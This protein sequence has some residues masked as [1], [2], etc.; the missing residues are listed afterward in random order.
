[1]KFSPTEPVGVAFCLD[2]RYDNK[3]AVDIMDKGKRILLKT[4]WNGAGYTYNDPT[5]EEFAIAV[6]E[7]YMFAETQNLSH[8][9]T[10]SQL[11]KVVAQIDPA[12][13]ANAFLYSLSTRA[14][15]Y[16]SAM[17]T[18]YYAKAVP[19]HEQPA[20]QHC[21]CCNWTDEH[22]DF[23]VQ[24]TKYGEISWWPKHTVENKSN[25][26][27]YKFGGRNHNQVQYALFDLIQF[28][29]LPSV[30]PTE[31]D[32]AMFR[33]ILGSIQELEP[34]SKAGAYQELLVKKK[35]IPTNRIEISSLID[36]LGLCG[37]LSTTEH[38]CPE[39]EFRGYLGIDPP[40]IHSDIAYPVCW[41]RARDGVNEARFRK[42]FG[43][44][45]REFCYPEVGY[46]EIACIETM[47]RRK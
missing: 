33:E 20:L 34:R 12:D 4:F 24:K 31:T 23:R 16:R 44:D 42:V 6:E 19:E 10:L 37:I 28:L 43:I 2:K 46:G 8:E 11:R 25:F 9:E 47:D 5:P 41:W 21:N 45:Y 29:K 27:R 35:I 26:E 40:E 32:R 36:I 17:G 14:L 22:C 3:K 13:V 39:V 30:T 38:P 18:Y 15:E 7:G 1:M